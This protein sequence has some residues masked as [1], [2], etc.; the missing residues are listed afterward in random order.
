MLNNSH[1]CALQYKYANIKIM[2]LLSFQ[3]FFYIE[4]AEWLHQHL[5]SIAVV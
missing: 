4:A 3:V 2:L 5:S 1:T